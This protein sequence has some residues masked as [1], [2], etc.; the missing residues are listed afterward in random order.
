MCDLP[1]N[2]NV[3]YKMGRGILTSLLSRQR[4]RGMVLEWNSSVVQT[5]VYL[6]RVDP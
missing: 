1:L 5:M 6:P 2:F 3:F 4:S